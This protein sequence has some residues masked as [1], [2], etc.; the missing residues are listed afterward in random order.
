MTSKMKKT[1]EKLQIAIDKKTGEWVSIFDVPSGRACNCK[2]PGPEGDLDLEARNKNKRPDIPLKPGQKMAYFAIARGQDYEVEPHP[3]TAIHLLAKEVFKEHK[4]LVIPKLEYKMEVLANSKEVKF[5][6]AIIEDKTL[7]SEYSFKPDAVGKIEKDGIVKKLLIEFK[8]THAVD[9]E[10]SGKIERSNISCVEIDLNGIDQLDIHGK[11]NRSEIKSRLLD[12][13]FAAW[14]YNA[15]AEKLYKKLLDQR[16]KEEKDRKRKEEEEELKRIEKMCESE[17]PKNLSFEEKKEWARNNAKKIEA[18][19]VK[20]VLAGL[21][22][23]QSLVKVKVN[24]DPNDN[25][26]FVICPQKERPKGPCTLFDCSFCRYF[27]DI[28]TI[29]DIE[30]DYVVCSYPKSV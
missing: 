23:N 21:P 26:E 30:S 17:M 3:E 20:L 28:R 22:K 15:E 24:E 29:S 9:Q 16:K 13:E 25:Y 14:I 4:T 27:R 5:D 7:L 19:K 8:K 1:P 10:K 11:P 18:E 6:R 12:P 2:Y